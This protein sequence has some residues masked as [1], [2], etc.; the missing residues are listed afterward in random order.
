MR[1]RSHIMSS[2]RKLIGAVTVLLV[3]S[4]SGWAQDLKEGD[5][6]RL[7]AHL[8]MTE[9]WLVSELDALSADQLSF[10]MTPESWSILEVVEHPSSPNLNTGSKR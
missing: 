7:L 8:D 2:M 5:R 1:V 3:F 6:Q 4:S 10:H 9:A